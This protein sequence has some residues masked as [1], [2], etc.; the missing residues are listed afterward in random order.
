MIIA[1]VGFVG[2]QVDSFLGATLEQRGLI[3][4]KT[5]NLVS[6]SAG[7]LLALYLG[8]MVGGLG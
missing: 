7:V 2:C 6:T 4:K 3:S 5:V 8:A 1:A